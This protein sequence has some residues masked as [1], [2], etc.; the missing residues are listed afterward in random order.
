MRRTPLLLVISALLGLAGCG[1]SS[2]GSFDG[3]G[4]NP[5]GTVFAVADRHELVA[6]GGSF[7]AVR[8]GES[9][10]RIHLFLSGALLSPDEEWRRQPASELLSFKKDLATL[11]GLLLENIPAPAALAGDDLEVQ[12]D[13][14]GRQGSGDFDAHLV[15]GLPP[16][17]VL[18]DQGLGADVSI[19]VL[20]DDVVIEPRG[21]HVNGRIEVKRGR[22]EGQSGE[23]ATG[24]VT[25]TFQAPLAPERL[26]KSNL[27]LGAP[28]MRCAAAAGPVRAGGCRDTTSDPYVDAT[29]TLETP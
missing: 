27:S 9:A 25:V 10:Q 14:S 20:F 5:S 22:A 7:L 23:V 21:G 15:V 6:S 19:K 28:V 1:A 17:P 24:E 2:L 11:D 3:V 18:E 12:L 8:R 13:E 26:G 16:E 29:G 4:F